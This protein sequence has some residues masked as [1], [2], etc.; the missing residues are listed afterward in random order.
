MPI[1]VGC[2][3]T[4]ESYK[5]QYFNDVLSLRNFRCPFAVDFD[6][7]VATYIKV[8]WYFEMAK[9]VYPRCP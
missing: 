8:K 7:N 1:L 5:S 4:F 6:K 3:V 2:K 9:I